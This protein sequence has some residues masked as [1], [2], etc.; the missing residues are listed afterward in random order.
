MAYDQF[1]IDLETMEYGLIK[2]QFVHEMNQREQENYKI[3]Q[4]R[5]DQEIID[6][7][8]QIHSLKLD[9][10]LEQTNKQNRA[11]Y[12]AIAQKINQLP[13]R[14][15]SIETSES[16][17]TSIQAHL[18]D[19]DL[20]H[21]QK[22]HRLILFKSVL[23]ALHNLK[24]IVSDDSNET[25]MLLASLPL[26]SINAAG[27]AAVDVVM[28]DAGKEAGKEGKDGKDGKDEN[29]VEEEEEGAVEA[30]DDMKGDVM[31]TS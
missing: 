20:L 8:S 30:D 15:A 9:L 11:E 1:R 17:T 26:D 7:Q 13:S 19:L 14:Q 25:A 22:T 5:I 16:L 4:G 28:D 29:G 18:Q 27:D 23:I 3:E 24:E 21:H 12:D 31:D 10:E 6:A 2:H